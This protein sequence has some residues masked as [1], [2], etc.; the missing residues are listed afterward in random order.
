MN[1]YD[2]NCF[3]SGKRG[4]FVI[5]IITVS[6]TLVVSACGP[7][8]YGSTRHLG[9][10]RSQLASPSVH[11]D[12]S[13]AEAVT[14]SNELREDA[15]T[16]LEKDYITPDCGRRDVHGIT[17]RRCGVSV[18]AKVWERRALAKFFSKVCGLDLV[19]AAVEIPSDCASRL[20]RKWYASL[21]ERYYRMDVDSV[22]RRC[23]ADP[24]D[25]MSNDTFERWCLEFHNAVVLSEYK[26]RLREVKSATRV[27]REEGARRRDAEEARSKEERKAVFQAIADGL[28]A[29]SAVIAGKRGFRCS[30]D[31]RTCWEL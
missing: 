19:N 30:T 18:V 5:N 22:G 29:V 27:E 24:E 13:A 21:A 12:T 3:L 25:C 28:G 31:G 10:S 1:M 9:A 17:P 8:P 11:A 23:D 2:L 6:A 4:R 15:V 14:L 16:N 26:D 20:N 7:S